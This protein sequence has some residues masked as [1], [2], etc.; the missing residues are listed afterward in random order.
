MTTACA[1]VFPLDLATRETPNGRPLAEPP[2]LSYDGILPFE[3]R[4]R[5]L[6][7]EHKA[8]RL[9][10]PQFTMSMPGA[11]PEKG[12]V[13]S[14]EMDEQDHAQLADEKASMTGSKPVK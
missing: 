10:V 7:P 3:K 6:F 12:E 2:I 14:M 9:I 8:N 11:W 4:F 13:L 5:L 1:R